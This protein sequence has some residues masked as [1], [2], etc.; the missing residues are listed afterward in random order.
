MKTGGNR[1]EDSMEADAVNI[2]IVS[3]DSRK[4]I[5]T[6]KPGKWNLGRTEENNQGNGRDNVGGIGLNVAKDLEESLKEEEQDK[7]DS[8][9]VDGHNIVKKEI[10]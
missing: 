5:T 8:D 1:F 3:T 7:K 6:V 4:A 10:K 9:K 2:N